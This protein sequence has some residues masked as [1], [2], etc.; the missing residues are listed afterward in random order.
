MALISGGAYS[1][2]SAS[3][4]TSSPE[5]FTTLYGTMVISSLTSSNFRPMNRLIEKIVFWEFVTCWRRAGVPTS[6]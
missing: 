2:P 1:L 6:R 4:R 3:T 5:P